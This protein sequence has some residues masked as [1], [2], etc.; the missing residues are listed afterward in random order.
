M[1]PQ[2]LTRLFRKAKEPE[3]TEA[4]KRA[5]YWT[6]VTGPATWNNIEELSNTYRRITQ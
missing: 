3:R 5:E 2:F 6:K 1:I 4:Q